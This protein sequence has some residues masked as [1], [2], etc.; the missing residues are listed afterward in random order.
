M[1]STLTELLA[2]KTVDQ[3]LAE[4]LAEL[5][6]MPTTA[7]QEGSVPRSL[8]K[9]DA[10]ALAD[11]HRTVALIA[12]GGFGS[13]AVGAWQTLF[14]KSRYDLD[15]FE[16][17]FAAGVFRVAC[18]GSSGPYTITASALLVTTPSGKRYR[19]S[20]TSNVVVSSGGYQDIPVK[21]ESPGS[22]FNIAAA[23]AMTIVSPA[24]AGLSVT[25]PALS[26]S[27]TWQTTIARDA[28]TDD[29]LRERSRERWGTLGGFNDDAVKFWASSAT[30][31]DG[32]SAGITRVKVDTRDG[33]GG[34]RVLV[35]GANGA[36]SGPAVTAA[37][38]LI[39][40]HKNKTDTATVVSATNRVVVVEAQVFARGG[41]SAG[42]LLELSDRMN[43][44]ASSVDIAGTLYISDLFY[45]LSRPLS[46]G[47][48]I[49]HVEITAPLVDI[50]L[51]AA[52]VLQI[53]S[54]LTS[55]TV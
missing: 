46:D 31:G 16:A 5:S 12:A 32:T 47:T 19:S 27:S 55:G 37:Q 48:L 18:A 38:N 24:F 22:D 52:E 41:L 50:A 3:V 7:W 28:E 35:A 30:L 8:L 36:A 25:N 43:S 39:N 4:L 1:A 6:A 23:T 10:T 11:L 15:R 54:T 14:A 21:A 13:T 26:G 45:E 40:L 42:Q 20:N 2:T 49:D 44:L 34:Y 9:A 51:G 29:E 53:S 33:L 17:T